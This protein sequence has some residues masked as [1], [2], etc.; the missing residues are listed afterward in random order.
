GSF[1]AGIDARSA[2]NIGLIPRK[3]PDNKIYFLE[4]GALSGAKKVLLEPQAEKEISGILSI[5]E[6]V[7]L[8][9]DKDFQDI[10]ADAMGF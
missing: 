4:E 6:H 1:G 2:K 8:H 3:I 5:C 9:K 10:F 7:E